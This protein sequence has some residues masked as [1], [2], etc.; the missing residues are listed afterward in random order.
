MVCIKSKLKEMFP[1][2]L[3]DVGYEDNRE[4]LDDNLKIVKMMINYYKICA[5]QK[6][7]IECRK[8]V[9]EDFSLAGVFI[10]SRLKNTDKKLS[11]YAKHIKECFSLNDLEWFCFLMSLIF[12]TDHHYKALI[13]SLGGAEE[14]GV[15]DYEIIMKIFYFVE[16]FDEIEY[17]SSQLINLKFKMSSLCFSEHSTKIDENILSFL[18][19]GEKKIALSGVEVYVPDTDSRG[20]LPI[21][22]RISKRIFEISELRPQGKQFCFYLHGESGIGKKTI[23]KR[24]SELMVKGTIIIDMK[25]Y[26]LLRSETFYNLI[27]SPL[28]EALIINGSI[29]LD[30]FEVFNEMSAQKYEYLEFLMENI[31]KFSREMFI[32][33]NRELS[34]IPVKDNISIINI[35]IESLN[36]KENAA[37]WKSYLK[38]LNGVTKVPSRELA[39]R[40]NFTPAQIKSTIGSVRSFWYWKGCKEL[41]IKDL[42]KCAYS[43]YI[44]KLS[45]KSTIIK[46]RYTW[47]DLVLDINEK[48]MIRNACD[49]IK[50][51]NIVYDEWGMNSRI[52][53]GRGLSMLFA[54]PPGTGKTMAAQVVANELNLELYKTDLSQVVSKYIGETE[55]NLNELFN[56]AK[57]SNAILLFDETDALF[58]K[59][60]AVK[61]SH[62]KNANLETS[63]LLQKMEE[64]DGISIMT[65]NYVEN[66]DVAFF[67]RISYVIH[68]A[69]P[70][71]AAREKIWKN[72][73]SSKT[74]LSS[75]I[76]FKYL[77]KNF[78][79]TGGSIKNIAVNAAFMAARDS[80]EV[81]MEHILKSLIYEIKKQGKNV[82]KDDLGEYGYL[83]K[84]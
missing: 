52:L 77:S 14:R 56:E 5:E 1:S 39:N 32:L 80:K 7:F 44:S 78:E 33:S 27:Y 67:R 59:R 45:S 6:I 83:I 71:A 72:M 41:K 69:F 10:S 47:K 48:N 64:Y 3:L 62:D 84:Q 60:T 57:K 35:P 22:E 82:I 40:F 4:Y 70:D 79:M 31:P 51:R 63:F 58:G 61:D 30:N 19:F 42:C 23:A 65:T 55:K 20:V 17:S 13:Q 2:N 73:F 49:Q 11:L 66:I 43:N 8:L 9:K 76:D 26:A 37:L 53:Y 50:Y 16:N 29:C 38:D 81:K 34:N 54:G 68:F 21:R 18:Y 24:A 12:D 28:R 46:S 74:P 25:L 36:G 75:D 15:L